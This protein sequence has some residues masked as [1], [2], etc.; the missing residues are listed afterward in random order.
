MVFLRHTKLPLS[1]P[2][3]DSNTTTQ[4]P[5]TTETYNYKE[6]ENNTTL[7]TQLCATTTIYVSI[8]KNK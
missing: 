3:N 8:T 7:N 1:V 2:N 6:E 4:L 5:K